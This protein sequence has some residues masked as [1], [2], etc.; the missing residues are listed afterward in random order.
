MAG[1]VGR[2]QI[3]ESFVHY[4]SESNFIPQAKGSH[5]KMLNGVVAWLF[6]D[7]RKLSGSVLSIRLERIKWSKRELVRLLE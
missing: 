6:A 2:R 7:F 1:Q 5:E 4:V 3:W